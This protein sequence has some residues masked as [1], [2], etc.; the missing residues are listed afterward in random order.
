MSFASSPGITGPQ[1]NPE[2]FGAGSINHSGLKAEGPS[3]S[4]VLTETIG[5]PLQPETDTKHSEAVQPGQVAVANEVPAGLSRG[6]IV[7]TGNPLDLSIEGEGLFVLADGQRDIYARTGSFAV[8]A[9]LDIVDP[10]TGY[11]LKR[12]GAEGEIEGFQIPGSSSIR[13]PYGAPLRARA[14]SD[15]AVS[16]NLSAS[17]AL[18]TVQNQTIASNLV[19]TY[20]NGTLAEQAT[21][22]GRLDQFSG[23]FASGT[24]TFGGFH[25]DG[26]ALDTDI[27]LAVNQNTTL[28]DIIGHLNTNVLDGATAALTNGRIQISDDTEGYS[29]T[30]I[31]MS[32]SGEGSLATPAYFEVVTPGTEQASNAGLTVYDSQG[33]K[34]ALSA[35]FVRTNTPNTWDMVLTSISGDVSEIPASQRRINGITFDAETGSYKGI[36]SLDP[37][38]FVVAFAHDRSNP[39]TIRINMGTAGKLDG[40]TQF[41]GNSTAAAKS[42]DGYASGTLSTVAVN[43]HGT[44]VG[45]FSNGVK[46]SIGA[47]QIAT[48]RNAAALERDADGYYVASAGSGMPA[49]RRAMSGGAGA[50]RGGTLEKSDTDVASDFVNMIQVQNSYRSNNML[51]ELTGFVG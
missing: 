9:N 5:K 48:F 45:T 25:K 38:Q 47:V 12:A 6:K 28:A 36:G 4:E 24:V 33:G 43:R 40:L 21:P 8:D 19:Y 11:H 18:S 15:I 31:A 34:H 27:S 16:G 2:A 26:K 51:A 17:A 14:T 3:F 32:Y 41:A 50:V 10:A 7:N 37:A 35:A 29:R 46:K 23:I 13:V 42:Q 30:D 49:V 44:L 22:I 1:S 20:D 39:Q